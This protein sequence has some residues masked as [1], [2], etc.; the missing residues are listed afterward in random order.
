MTIEELIDRAAATMMQARNVPRAKLHIAR[1]CRS[2]VHDVLEMAAGSKPAGWLQRIKFRPVCCVHQEER[3]PLLYD[4]WDEAQADVDSL[5]D[6]SEDGKY[7]DPRI[8]PL[9]AADELRRMAKELS[10]KPESEHH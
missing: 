7:T 4:S 9:I 8:V 6:P 2:L 1:A 10:E 5:M 3:R